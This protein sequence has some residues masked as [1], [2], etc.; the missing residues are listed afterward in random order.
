MIAREEFSKKCDDLV[1][2]EEIEKYNKCKI[3]MWIV[4][5]I[6]L[7]VDLLL[8]YL[9]YFIWKPDNAILMIATL[10]IASIYIVIYKTGYKWG[11]LKNQYSKE[12]L[13]LLFDGYKYEFKPKSRIGE[14]VFKNS[15]F[16]TNYDDYN[17][18]DH[19]K[20][21]IP[22]DDGT[23]S[24]VCLSLCD[25]RV[26]KKRPKIGLT[27]GLNG[28]LTRVNVPRN[29]TVFSG[30]FGC[31]DFPFEFKCN[32]SININSKGYEKINL[33]DEKFNKKCKTYTDNQLE[34]LVI[35]T[36]T[37]MNKLKACVERIP[38]FKVSI[39]REGKM[40]F[41]MNRN[42]F[43]LS[44]SFRKPTGKVFERFYDDVNDILLII[45][46]IKNNNKVFKM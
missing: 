23:P 15:G 3:K 9:I 30:V 36:P 31:V 1:P 35:L 10:V 46:E 24:N 19:L 28:R 25:L 12:V 42:M 39:T 41:A 45:N 21:Q 18:E 6:T 43:E 27:L 37:L 40:F 7:I 33:E 14:Q 34:A 11:N 26:T 8:A 13:D 17:G 38:G 16:S 4:L 20:V 32:L 29:V 44:K 5:P 22:N 2:K